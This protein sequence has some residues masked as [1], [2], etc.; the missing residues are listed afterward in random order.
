MDLAK[1]IDIELI[2]AGASEGWMVANE[3]ADSGVPVILTPIDNIPSSF[4]SPWL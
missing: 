3:L 4:D 1:R 2:I